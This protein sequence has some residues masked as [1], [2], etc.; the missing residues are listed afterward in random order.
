[1]TLF[2]S[3]YFSRLAKSILILV[4]LVSTNLW[5]KV[6]RESF[7]NDWLFYKGQQHGAE[8][9]N[10]S[11]DKWRKLDLPH[12]WAIE[13]PFDKA[14]S[15]RNGG[16][17]VFGTA[18]YRKHFKL[19][20]DLSRKVVS[21]TFDGVMA[22]SQ[23]FVNGHKVAER[24]FGYIAF[25]IDITP[26]INLHGKDNVVSVKLSPENFSARWY[27]GAGIYRN[28]WLEINDE[29]HVKQWETVVS[30][31]IVK[32]SIAVVDYKT[33]IANS[34]YSDQNVEVI[35]EIVTTEGK[36]IT[37]AN[38]AIAIA[39]KSELNVSH[40]LDI[41][42]PRL[43][44]INDPYRYRV[45]TKIMRNG[46]IIE[47]ESEPLGVRQIEYKANDGFWLN[48][49]RVQ[50][51]G[52]CLHH[53]NG[54]L[55]ASVN[56]RAI[57]RKF[58]IMQEMGA[59]SVR[60]SHN[61]PS[62]ELVELADKMGVL[63]QVEAFDMW[64]IEKPSVINGYNKD[65]PKWHETDLRD[66]VKQY[67][68]NPSV[69]MWSSG[70]EV[71]E[72]K[73]KDGWKL[74]KR[75]NDIIHDEDP[76]R[77][78]THGISM[79]PFPV[80]NGF[81][82]QVDIKGFNYKAYKY[83]ELKEK[84]PDW[85]MLGTE[86][87]SVVSTRGVYH[88]PIE[89]YRK[90]VSKYVTSFDVV[91]PPWAYVPDLEFENLKNTPAVMGEYIWTGFDYL[92][93]PT[94][95][96]GRD[97]GNKFYWNQ[98][99]PARSSSFGAVDLVG[100]KKDRF[101]LYQ[102]QWTDTPMVHVLPHWNWPNKIGESIPVM[103]YTNAE[104]VELFVNGKSMG[105]KVKGVDTV[106]LPVSLKYDKSV[107]HFDSPYRLRWDVKYQPGTVKVVAYNQGKVVAEK[108]IHTAGNAAKLSLTPDRTEIDAD[109]YDVSYIT[110]EVQDKNGNMVP[111]ADNKIQFNVS[112][113]GEIA[114]VGNGDS[115]TEEPFI[116]DYR[117][118]FYGKAMLIVKSKKNTAGEI[119]ISA[120]ADGLD[121]QPISIQAKALKA[122]S[123]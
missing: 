55:G 78:V 94:P 69:I 27:P 3:L 70:N 95:Y 58:E 30:T 87:S 13:G 110:V 35:T 12:D 60:T 45:V 36:V 84:H 107:K 80:E 32:P 105:K 81:A 115:A 119:K 53:D 33:T 41:S 34:G 116:A 113:A 6:D 100:F 24:P 103:A 4:T 15:A 7:N 48:G 52:V 85:I 123:E 46:A 88:F 101:Y 44:D 57:E 39:G 8:L 92:G 63:L 42:K 25:Q 43:W 68:N 73:E 20:T 114:A 104:E 109:G 61:P 93:E 67:R 23:V 117:R 11:D 40:K 18:W 16:L 2:N 17:P 65:F 29:V 72:Q 122:F 90:H 111:N 62:P 106:R 21:L 54:P 19:P 82:E 99:W 77:L 91:T 28:T 47:Q 74:A 120:F 71:H 37:R 64:E 14:Y 83:G 97:H 51:Q 98:D 118:A 9:A 49:R 86:T 1:M 10:F 121:S 66:M 31:P 89:K 76:T 112:G 22:N 79:Y 59:N 26:Y 96:G 38:K 108:T 5:A 50:I 75:L 56:T 102:S